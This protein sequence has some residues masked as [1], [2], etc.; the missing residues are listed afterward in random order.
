MSRATERRVADMD[1]AQVGRALRDGLTRAVD[2]ETLA[3]LREG[4]SF[5]T[6]EAVVAYA[7]VVRVPR[8]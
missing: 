4:A 1:A 6:Y 3:R 2:P 8:A 7:S 5:W